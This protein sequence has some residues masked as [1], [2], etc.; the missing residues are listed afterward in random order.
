MLIPEVSAVVVVERMSVVSVVDSP[1]VSVVAS[2][3]SVATVSVR[4]MDA[5]SVPNRVEL[6]DVV[7]PT[8]T[9]ALS[10]PVID[11]LVADTSVVAMLE[12]SVVVTVTKTLDDSDI[13]SELRSVVGWLIRSTAISVAAIAPLSLPGRV[14][15][16]F[17][18]SEA[19]TETV[20]DADC[21]M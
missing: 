6:N 8:D 11:R 17:D 2:V 15:P 20:S 7:S 14:E 13:D 9:A 3:T 19:A 16:M 1:D 4:E 21:V 12:V 5:V 10:E 18:M